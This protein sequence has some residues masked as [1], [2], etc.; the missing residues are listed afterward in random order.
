MRSNRG[1]DTGPE[2]A[3]RSALHRRGYRF[4]VNHRPLRGVRRTVDVA[5]T[6]WKVAVFVDGCFWHGCPEHRTVPATNRAYWEPKLARN[7]ERDRETEG[8]FGASGWRVVR[9][10]EHETVDDA[11]RKVAA[12]VDGLR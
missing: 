9:V 1:R 2:L 8:L 10:W 7:V 11:V 12:A 4:R 6:R 3:L 5:F